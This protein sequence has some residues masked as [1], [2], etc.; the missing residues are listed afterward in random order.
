MKSTEVVALERSPRTWRDASVIL[1]CCLAGLLAFHRPT[2]VTMVYAWSEDPF[3]HGYFVGPAAAWIA[4]TR[5][6]QLRALTPVA[7]VAALPAIGALSLFWLAGH[8]SGVDVVQQFSV[9]AMGISITWA[10]LGSA[11][12]RLLALPFGVLFFALP[13]GDTVAP[14]L[15]TFTARAAATLLQYSAIPVMLEEQVISTQATIWH[16]SEACGGIHYLIASV[17][18]AYVYS[19]VAY[20]QWGHRIQFLAASALVPVAGN[21]IRVYTTIL[22]DEVGATRIVSGMSHYLYGLLVFA[23]MMTLLYVTCGRWR[24]EPIAEAGLFPAPHAAH[25]APGGW[26]SALIAAAAMLLIAGGPITATAL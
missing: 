14:M 18:V 25:A 2:I 9:V 8:R 1:G 15:Q 13:V 7:A 16:V 17:A 12:A 24:E 5:R 23:T 6:T 22:L 10:I 3:G 11:V 20:R 19:N 21:I 4:W 26:R